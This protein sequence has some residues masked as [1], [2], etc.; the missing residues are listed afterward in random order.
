[1]ELR[2]LGRTGLQV[3]KFAL[4]TMALGAWGNR[5]HDDAC[6]VVNEA[7]DQGINLVDTADMYSDGESEVIVGKA[8]KSRRDDVVLAT[9][10]FFPMGT[11]P[12]MRGGSRRYLVRAAEACLR[13]LGTDRIDLFQ[14]HRPDP[15]TD[16][17]E[18]L[19]ALSDLVHAGKVLAIG[20]SSFPPEQIVEA[21]WMA[22]RRGHVRFS[23]EQPPYSIF[24]RGIEGHMLPTARKYGLGVLTWSPL[25]SG[26]LSG[27]YRTSRDVQMTDFKRMIAHKFDDMLPGNRLKEQALKELAPLADGAGL[28]MTQLALAFAA[29][30]PA[31]TSVIIGPRT[32]DQLHELLSAA[33]IELAGDVLDRIDE[34]VPPGVTLNPAD[35]DY[36][37]PS[38][39]DARLRRRA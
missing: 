28:S 14:V 11:D 18:T 2:T 34:I 1:M 25:N 10:V 9:K 33:D 39:A 15:S 21:Q 27:R 37:P 16:I 23:T 6:R 19:G 4:G 24:V 26:W 5:D 36:T 35:A 22:E 17:D 13:R 3:S 38:L 31:I 12:N 32:C 30:H 20:S 29:A 7:L 8:I